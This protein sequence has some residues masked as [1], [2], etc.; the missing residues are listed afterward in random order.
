MDKVFD[1]A[2]KY[3]QDPAMVIFKDHVAKVTGYHMS[4]RQAVTT[5]AEAKT[6]HLILTHIGGISAGLVRT[7]ITEPLYLKGIGAIYKGPVDIAE[8][9]SIFTLSLK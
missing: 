2:K 9:G 6:K 4:T 7:L 1:V 8:N 3:S 5:A